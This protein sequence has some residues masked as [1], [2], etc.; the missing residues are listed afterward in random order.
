M[1]SATLL[2]PILLSSSLVHDVIVMFP[3][4]HPGIFHR[5]SAGV[6]VTNNLLVKG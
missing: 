6:D 3:P 2:I 4:V 5:L 1:R